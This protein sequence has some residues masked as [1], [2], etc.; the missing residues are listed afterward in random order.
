MDVASARA[1]SQLTHNF[2]L[3]SKVANLQ[4]WTFE[5]EE[6][7]RK[8]NDDVKDIQSMMS[9]VH[10][11]MN[12]I[13]KSQSVIL[14]AI[15]L[16]ARQSSSSK[17]SPLP[18]ISSV[19]IKEIIHSELQPLT[20]HVSKINSDVQTLKE[21]LKSDWYILRSQMMEIIEPKSHLSF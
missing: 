6:D 21:E 14:Q 1:A 2:V 18:S 19:P 13:L 7:L 17:P 11:Q 8:V 4:S 9:H 16:N 20:A 3:H 10:S 12:E 5:I 15:D